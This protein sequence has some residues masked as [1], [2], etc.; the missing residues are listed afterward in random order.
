M[1]GFGT[2]AAGAGNMADDARSDAQSIASA[3]R[4]GVNA[5]KRTVNSAV[6]DTKAVKEAAGQIASGNYLGAAKTAL[7]NPMTVIKIVLVALFIFVIPFKMVFLL[8][9]THPILTFRF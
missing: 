5:A 6:K 4:S 8:R 3:A 1:A 7:E 9:L 2:N